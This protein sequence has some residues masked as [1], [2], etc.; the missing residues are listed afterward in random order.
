MG[1]GSSRW[2][3]SP[4]AECEGEGYSA[5]LLSPW[6]GGV[7]EIQ[8]HHLS[9]RTRFEDERA[10][11]TLRSRL[12]AIEGVAIASDTLRKRPSFPIRLL[13]D[14]KQRQVFYDA[15]EWFIETARG[16]HE[17]SPA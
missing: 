9:Y 16:A 5:F 3:G 11:D 6:A 4:G 12:N 10:R 13:R 15:L 17:D 1:T 8:F 2:L 14:T 7:I